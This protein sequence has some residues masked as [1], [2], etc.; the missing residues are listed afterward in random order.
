M[1]PIR[2]DFFDVLLRAIPEVPALLAALRAGKI[3]GSTYIGECACLAGTIA[4]AR[5]VPY[6]ELGFVDSSR[7]AERWFLAVKKGDRPET[8]P[9]VKIT[10]GWI[11]EF[12]ALVGQ[13][14]AE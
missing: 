6:G 14:V 13:V 8:N 5:R 11:L 3:D 7:P 9:I 10:V 1:R 2:T 12:Q 4:N